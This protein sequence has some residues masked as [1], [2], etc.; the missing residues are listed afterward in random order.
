[1][2]HLLSRHRIQRHRARRGA[3]TVVVLV[4]LLVSAMVL[5]SLL[6]L[7]MLHDAQLGNVQMRLQS[8]WLADSGLERAA[9]RLAA[10]PAYSGETWTIN[11]S[12]LGGPDTGAVVI[13]VENNTS[14]SDRRLVIVEAVYPAEGTR[15]ARLTRQ[16]TITLAQEK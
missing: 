8:V 12:D 4:C 13:R 1:M 5:A 10:D 3:F 14:P 11:S 9:S 6:K 2:N 15:Q 16:S 7:A